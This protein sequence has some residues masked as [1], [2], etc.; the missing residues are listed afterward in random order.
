[1]SKEIALFS[2]ANSGTDI[3]PTENFH[4]E[5]T[6]D[7][8]ILSEHPRCCKPHWIILITAKALRMRL[9]L[10]SIASLPDR[11]GPKLNLIIPEE[12]L[13]EADKFCYSGSY[14]SINGPIF[15]EM[16]SRTQKVS[17][18]FTNFNYLWY[19]RK[20]R[21][22]IKGRVFVTDMV[23]SDRKYQKTVNFWTPLTASYF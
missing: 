20:I 15:N 19:R 16:S 2:G 4:L 7:V 17:S 1:M 8:V 11:A 10:Q 12:E 6:Q 13:A 5:Y 3:F 21:L 9:H 14:I 23:V 18:A 22:S